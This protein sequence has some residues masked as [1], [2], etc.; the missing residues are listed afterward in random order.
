M[1]VL[2]FFACFGKQVSVRSPILV[3]WQN[4]IVVVVEQASPKKETW[5]ATSKISGNLS[6]ARMDCRRELVNKHML[7]NGMCRSMGEGKTLCS[8]TLS[9]FVVT[10]G[11]ADNKVVCKK[12]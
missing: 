6:M 3:E 4:P 7:E 1:L 12:G 5:E 11:I 8:G 10:Y 2:T 9:G